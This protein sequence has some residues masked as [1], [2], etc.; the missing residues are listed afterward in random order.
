MRT[1]ETKI[2]TFDELSEEA[3]ENAVNSIR[4]KGIDTDF[5]YDDAYETVK[6][7]NDVFGCTENNRTW[8][9]AE[10]NNLSED[11][12]NL[13]GLRLRTYIINNFSHELIKGKYFSLWSKTDVSYKYHKEGYPVL[14]SRNSKV[15]FDHC[16]VLTGVCYD[17]TILGP[18]YD[19]I[20]NY[21]GKQ[22]Y[23]IYMDF[24]TLI[25]DCFECLER[26]IENEITARNEDESIIEDI[27]ANGY[28]FTEDGE[29]I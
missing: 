17:D 24:Q 16:C 10:L 8:L 9:E 12:L 13:K 27:K 20:Y 5:I 19:F 7:F 18:V 6:Q 28:E 3:K 1:I 29:L 26:D 14:K 21:K 11:V 23:Y 2:F 25:N 15:L 22:D 4:S